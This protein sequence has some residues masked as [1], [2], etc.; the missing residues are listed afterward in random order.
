MNLLRYALRSF[1]CWHR[2]ILFSWGDTAIHDRGSICWYRSH[3][4]IGCVKCGKV[5]TWK[6]DLRDHKL[7]EKEAALIATRLLGWSYWERRPKF[8]R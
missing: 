6:E 7:K 2:F 1:F 8:E 3:V 4:R 5:R